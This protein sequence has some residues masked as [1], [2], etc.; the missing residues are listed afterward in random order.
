MESNIFKPIKVFGGEEGLVKTK[1]RDERKRKLCLENSCH[2]IEV[3]KDYNI[4]DIT[5]KINSLINN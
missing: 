5:F 4:D 3:T 2:L 1:E